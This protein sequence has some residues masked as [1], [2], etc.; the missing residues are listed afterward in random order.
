MRQSFGAKAEETA[1]SSRLFYGLT[2]NI[3]TS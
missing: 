1:R 2:V 3:E